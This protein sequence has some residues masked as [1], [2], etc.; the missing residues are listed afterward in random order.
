LPWLDEQ[1]RVTRKGAPCAS[2]PQA[3]QLAVGTLAARLYGAFVI[4]NATGTA[5][6]STTPTASGLRRRLCVQ[7]PDA[8][9]KHVESSR[10]RGIL[11]ISPASSIPSFK[12]NLTNRNPLFRGFI[13]A[14]LAH[15]SAK[16][17]G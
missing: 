3:C 15:G 14:A 1:T 8:G 5:T 9:R 11:S 4:R 12:A 2:G 6:S 17:Q 10:N 16:T 7:R 13:A